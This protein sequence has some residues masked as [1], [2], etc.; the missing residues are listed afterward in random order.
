MLRIAVVEDEEEFIRQIGIYIKKFSKE[1][2]GRDPNG[3][4]SGW[5]RNLE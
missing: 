4:V 5:C 3:C 2:S 1:K